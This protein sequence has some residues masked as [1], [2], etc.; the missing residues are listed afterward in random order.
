MLTIVVW[1]LMG[2]VAGLLMICKDYIDGFDLSV[3]AILFPFGAGVLGI[4]MWVILIMFCLE[5][6]PIKF[7]GLSDFFNK[8][9]IKGRK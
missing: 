7:K 3:K 4:F 5:N 2:F 8:T 6:H 1:Y 9:I